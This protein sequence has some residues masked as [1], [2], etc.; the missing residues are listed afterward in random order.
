MLTISRYAMTDATAPAARTVAPAAVLYADTPLGRVAS[1]A[2]TTHGA[3]TASLAALTVQLCRA[4]SSPRVRA[5]SRRNS[6]SVRSIVPTSVPPTSRVTRSASTMRSATGSASRSFRASSDSPNL[7]VARK[8][9]ANETKAGRSSSGPRVPS[10]ATACGNERPARMPPARWSTASGHAARVARTRE[11]DRAPT[12]AKG[13]LAAMAAKHTATAGARVKPA[14]TR[15]ATTAPT[16]ATVTSAAG[17]TPGAPA[18]V[19]RSCIRADHPSALPGPR[20]DG[21]QKLVH[22]RK[23]PRPRVRPRSNAMSRRQ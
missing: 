19:R 15:N 21:V 2:R 6:L 4:S 9:T 23:S 12:S 7:P 13:A 5:S 14:T 11:R 1:R 16:P 20:G 18:R 10:C 8:S 17:V 3:A 22:T